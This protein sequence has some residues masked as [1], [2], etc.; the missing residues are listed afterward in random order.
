VVALPLDVCGVDAPEVAH[1]G[2]V[3]VTLA[4]RVGQTAELL[5]VD[6]EVERGQGG[7]A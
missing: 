1:D 7:L 6:V 3:L 2:E 5:P 4:A